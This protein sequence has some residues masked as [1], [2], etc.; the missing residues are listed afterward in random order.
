MEIIDNCYNTTD[1]KKFSDF[2][3]KY[4]N[5]IN[6]CFPKEIFDLSTAAGIWCIFNSITGFCGNLLTLLALPYAAKRKK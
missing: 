6:L 2:C 4:P 1:V 3:I 5:E